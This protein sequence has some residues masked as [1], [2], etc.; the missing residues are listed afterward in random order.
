MW[1]MTFLAVVDDHIVLH[2][3]TPS[4]GSCEGFSVRISSR[5][6]SDIFSEQ[7]NSNCQCL[8]MKEDT[9]LDSSY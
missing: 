7:F 8:K 5:S 9:S 2:Q 1:P 3:H 4:N 6:C